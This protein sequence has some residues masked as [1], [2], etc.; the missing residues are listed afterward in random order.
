MVMVSGVQM[1]SIWRRRRTRTAARFGGGRGRSSHCGSCSIIAGG[2][3]G[4]RG[5]QRRIVDG[6]T[7]A[8]WRVGSVGV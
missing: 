8:G 4:G 3:G 5:G 2:D 7:V 6:L 1:A